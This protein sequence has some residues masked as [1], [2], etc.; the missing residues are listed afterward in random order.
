[1]MKQVLVFPK[2]FTFRSRTEYGCT[3][4]GTSGLLCSSGKGWIRASGF[5]PIFQNFI[6]VVYDN[7]VSTRGE[8]V[9]SVLF[10]YCNLDTILVKHAGKIH[11]KMPLGTVCLN[12]NRNYQFYLEVDKDIKYATYTPSLESKSGGL[13]AGY[14]GENDTTIDPLNLLH[15]DIETQIGRHY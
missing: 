1:M 8:D 3:F 10:R 14:R 12:K 2:G 6:C 11:T 9:G 4:V 7:V 5:S 13:H 15:I